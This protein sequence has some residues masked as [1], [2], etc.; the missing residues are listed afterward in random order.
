[1]LLC[2]P[3]I[4]KSNSK[5]SNKGEHDVVKLVLLLVD[6]ES[7]TPETLHL[8]LIKIFRKTQDTPT[9]L[10]SFTLSHPNRMHAGFKMAL[11][12]T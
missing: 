4:E 10:G 8:I 5:E 2:K 3:A 7:L 9:F 12:H 6:P 1:M 11:P